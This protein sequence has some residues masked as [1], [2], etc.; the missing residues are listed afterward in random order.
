[1]IALL[2]STFG[3]SIILH[4]LK[5]FFLQE[6]IKFRFDWDGILERLCI[7]YI[8]IWAIDLW[9]FIPIII[10]T[11]LLVR[12]HLLNSISRITQSKDPGAASQKVIYKA[13]LTFDVFVGPALAILVG[14]I[15]R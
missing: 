15:F 13:E 5:N 1:M 2:L 9:L 4:F 8:L 12:L 7:S 11:K 10:L 3:G 6:K 14:V